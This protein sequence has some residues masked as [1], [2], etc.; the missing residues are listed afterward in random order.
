MLNELQLDPC[1][2]LE[3]MREAMEGPKG[4]EQCVAYLRNK[5]AI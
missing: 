3:P 2:L 5:R 1:E 4:N